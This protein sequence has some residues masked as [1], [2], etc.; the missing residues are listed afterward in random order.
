MLNESILFC[1]F[2]RICS[3]ICI[4]AKIKKTQIV[5]F[6]EREREKEKGNLCQNSIL[7]C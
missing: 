2:I 4:E 1:C 5:F 7:N 3:Q 6:C